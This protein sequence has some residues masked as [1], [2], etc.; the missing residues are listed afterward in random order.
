M[1][2][3]NISFVVQ[4]NGLPL[5][6]DLKEFASLDS[7]FADSSIKKVTI[8]IIIISIIIIII[9]SSSSSSSTVNLV[10]KAPLQSYST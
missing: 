3:S 6:E 4:H 8:I 7:L 2:I 10:A 5:P 9:S 1:R